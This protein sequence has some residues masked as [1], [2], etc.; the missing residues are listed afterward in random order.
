MHEA[1]RLGSTIAAGSL[2]MMS[3][4]YVTCLTKR[5]ARTSSGL[6]SCSLRERSMLAIVQ[7]TSCWFKYF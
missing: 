6:M 5:R 3:I 1:R 2:C 7:E 4:Q